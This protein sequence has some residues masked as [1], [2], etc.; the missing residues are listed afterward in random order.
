MASLKKYLDVLTKIK[1]DRGEKCECCGDPA[2]HGHHIIRV[3]ETSIH[4]ELVYEPANIMLL[5]SDCHML[6][7]PLI[8]NAEWGI[9]KIGRGQMFSH[10]T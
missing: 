6:M 8:R 5:C 10:R 2:R 7:H 4:N 9:A 3:G 1:A